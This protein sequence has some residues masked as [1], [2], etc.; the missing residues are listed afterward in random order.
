MRGAMKRQ[1]E[2]DFHTL[3]AILEGGS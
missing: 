3:K 2:N 1:A